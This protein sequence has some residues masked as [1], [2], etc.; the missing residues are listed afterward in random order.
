ML[1]CGRLAILYP[2]K[3]DPVRLFFGRRDLR[4]GGICYEN[5][6][7]HRK[8]FWLLWLLWPV[9]FIWVAA[10]GDK[11]VA[12]AKRVIGCCPWD[13]GMEEPA[14][15]LPLPPRPPQRKPLLRRAQ[16]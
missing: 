7:C 9:R 15:K 3:F 4:N 16:G 8:G 11:I 13:E 1:F 6:E 2:V 12:W 5:P 14:R 10:Y